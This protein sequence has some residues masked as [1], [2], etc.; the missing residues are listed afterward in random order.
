MNQTIYYISAMKAISKM[1]LEGYHTACSY[2]WNGI[3]PAKPLLPWW[4]QGSFLNFWLVFEPRWSY[5]TSRFCSDL[6]IRLSQDSY[7]AGDV[8]CWSLLK[9]A[10]LESG[11]EVRSSEPTSF[12][13]LIGAGPPA[14]R[15]AKEETGPET[16]ILFQCSSMPSTM[17]GTKLVT[18]TQIWL[19][20]IIRITC[21]NGL[22]TW[23]S[24]PYLIYLL[25]TKLKRRKKW[26]EFIQAFT[27]PHYPQGHG[28]AHG[29]HWLVSAVLW[30]SILNPM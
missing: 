20:M 8:R 28:L 11:V 19:V 26:L 12:R 16:T 27:T 15:A 7:P 22:L 10:A 30:W 14:W 3:T 24:S 29:Y 9:I 23:P 18:M 1:G 17:L 6:C 5:S 13:Y 25:T 4:A 2:W 21:Y